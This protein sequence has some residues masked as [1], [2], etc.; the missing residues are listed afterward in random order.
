MRKV[1]LL[2]L[3][4]PACG[5]RQGPPLKRHAQVQLISGSPT[6]GWFPV[7][8]AAAHLTNSLYA[9]QPISVVPGAGGISNPLRVGTGLSEIGMSYGPFLKLAVEGNNELYRE[10]FPELRGIAS[11]LVNQLHLVVSA[12]AGVADLAT[13]GS[14]RPRLRVGAG[15][16]GS[17]ELFALQQVLREY[18]VTYDDIK[19]WGGRVDRLN[20]EERSDAWQNRHL[21][22]VAFFINNPAAS[23]IELMSMRKN[24]R[25]LTLEEPVRDALAQKWGLLKYTIPANDYPNQPEEVHTVGMPYVFFSST[26]LDS[27]LVYDMT[28][29]IAENRER[30]LATHSAFKDWKPEDMPLGLGIEIHAGAQRFYR[31]RGWIP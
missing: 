3:L 10:A 2:L 27:E 25:L 9:G 30:F 11:M 13:L 28:R 12:E 20:T 19:A 17:T 8:A 5:D 23:L 31:E 26:R 7:A 15:P 21:D 14:R 4:L 29:E 1:L 22:L 18:G 6:G 16:T 24:S